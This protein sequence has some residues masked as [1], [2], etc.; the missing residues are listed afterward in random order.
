MRHRDEE[1]AGLPR[2]R[3][4]CR[5][6][7]YNTVLGMP[8]WLQPPFVHGG[9]DKIAQVWVQSPRRVQKNAHLL[10]NRRLS[11]QEIV[12]QREAALARMEALDRLS[13]LHLIT[14]EN[15]V[16]SGRCHPKQVC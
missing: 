14:D 15:E 3:P 7:A 2:D 13:Q 10:R 11:L 12:E 8:S 6:D 5:G 16:L 9:R 4:C 1:D